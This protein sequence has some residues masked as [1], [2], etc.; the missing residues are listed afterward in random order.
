MIKTPSLFQNITAGATSQIGIY[1]ANLVSL[2]YLARI[3][4]TEGLGQLVYVQSIMLLVILMVDFGFSWSAIKA[5]SII[6]HDKEQLSKYFLSTWIAQWILTIGAGVL[7]ILISYQTD[8]LQASNKQLFFGYLI[9][10]GYTLFPFWLLHGL[11][12]IRTST[13]IQLISKITTIPLLFILVKSPKDIDIAILFYAFCNLLGGFIFIFY[14]IHSN[15]ISWARPSLSDIVLIYKSGWHTFLA[16]VNISL[17]SLLIPIYLNNISGPSA[18]GLY[19]L[20]DKVKSVILAITGPIASALYPRMSLL[21]KTNKPEFVKLAYTTVVW[22][23][24][25]L[26]PL[27]CLVWIFSSDIATLI[28]G[29][30][31]INATSTIRCLAFLP[32]LTSTSNVLGMQIMLPMGMEKSLSKIYFGGLLLVTMLVFIITPFLQAEGAAISLLLAEIFM[33]VAMAYKI[34]MIKFIN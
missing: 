16:K 33:L 6:R 10:A 29:S 1:V 30:Q 21:A 25:A 8:I 22:Q 11:E 28:G 34:K 3:L 12:K 9:V 13:T 14:T 5:I 18:L 4:G 17:C 32:I 26:L 31:F 2:P 20:A 24:L 19:N 7:L 23:A 15:I 27:C